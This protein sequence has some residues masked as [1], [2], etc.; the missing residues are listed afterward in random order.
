MGLVVAPVLKQNGSIVQQRFRTWKLAEAG[1]ASDQSIA[2]V[3]SNNE[4]AI[5]RA[6][7]RRRR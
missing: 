3:S 1:S 7:A 5:N 4:A 6:A 2:W